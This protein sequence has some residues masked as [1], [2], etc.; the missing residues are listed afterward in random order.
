MAHKKALYPTARGPTIWRRP[1]QTKP[2]ANTYVNSSLDTAA[3]NIWTLGPA[4]DELPRLRALEFASGPKTVL[5]VYVTA[6]AWEARNDP[7]LES[8][9]AAPEQDQRH[10]ELLFMTVWYLGSE[11]LGTGHT[12]PIGEP[13]LSGS[14]CEHFLVS[15]PYP[16]GSKLE[17]Y[18]F[19]DWQLHVLWLLPFTKAEREFKVK[20]SLEALEQR[21][22]ASALEYWI[23]GRASV[24]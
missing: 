16:F 22:D 14:A 20:E 7:Q 19:R 15:S 13:W 4:Q 3:R 18:N 23:P 17:M 21:F 1:T 6:G 10:V 12:L 9:I 2:S 11:G 24:V 5:W 8:L